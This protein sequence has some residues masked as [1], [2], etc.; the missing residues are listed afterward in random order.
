MTIRVLLAD[1]QALIR[2]GFA[3]IL[4]RTPDIEVVAEAADGAAAVRLAHEHQPD[5][6]LMDIR[7]PDLDGIEATRELCAGAQDAHPRVLIVTTYGDDEYVFESLRAGASGFLLKTPL[8]RSSST[9]SE[10]SPRATPSSARASPATSSS[11]S[12]G[13]LRP[14]TASPSKPSPLESATSSPSSPEASPTSK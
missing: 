11:T 13:R 9:P 10:S 7:M 4:A 14:T 2:Q 8:P 12:P 3:A 6:I 5:I 1:D